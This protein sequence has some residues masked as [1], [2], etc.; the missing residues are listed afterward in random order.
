[1][2]RESRILFPVGFGEQ[3]ETRAFYSAGCG[4]IDLNYGNKRY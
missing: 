1:M 2:R 3:A 4:L